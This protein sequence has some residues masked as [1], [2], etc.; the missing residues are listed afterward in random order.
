MEYWL[1]FEIVHR[2]AYLFIL[3]FAQWGLPRQ[4]SDK[5]EVSIVMHTM[6]R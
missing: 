3:P 1:K 4:E 2:D 6:T 5:T